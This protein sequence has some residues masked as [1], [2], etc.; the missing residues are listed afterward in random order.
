VIPRYATPRDLAGATFSDADY[1]DHCAVGHAPLVIPVD[2]VDELVK[3]LRLAVLEA[4]VRV[5]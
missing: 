1:P 2:A 3:K 5:M 4:Q